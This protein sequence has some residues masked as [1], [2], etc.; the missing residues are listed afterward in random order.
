MSFHHE[1][2][3][4]QSE[5]GTWN[6]G[7]YTR[8]SVGY[9]EDYDSEWDDTYDNSFQFVSSGHATADDAWRSWGGPNPGSGYEVRYSPGTAEEIKH[10]EDLAARLYERQG[11]S[12]ISPL[13]GKGEAG[14]YG[15]PRNRTLKAI[16]AERDKIVE[17][18]VRYQESA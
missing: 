15:P 8:I 5:D 6:Q 2:V 4:W 10:Y 18:W 1:N 14:Y 16:K 13:F 7:F 11:V 3:T 9:S 17:S 12:S